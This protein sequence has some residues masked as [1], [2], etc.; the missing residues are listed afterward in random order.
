MRQ[1]GIPIRP[2]FPLGN[3]SHAAIILPSAAFKIA[4]GNTKNIQDMEI[5]IED[6]FEDIIG[7]C[8]RGLKIDDETLASSAGID[9]AKL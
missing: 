7:K 2:A 6:F 5:P 1:R 9:V 4:P 3:S 8:Q